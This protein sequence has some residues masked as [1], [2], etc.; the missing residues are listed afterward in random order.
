MGTSDQPASA[1][2]ATRRGYD[3]ALRRSHAEQTRAQ[4][5]DAATRLFSERGWAVGMRE[6]AAEADVSFETVYAKFGSK[7][8]LFLTAFDVA[9]VGDDQPVA[10]ARRPEFA[11]LSAG[12]RHE[13][14]AAAAAL[15]TDIYGRT[16]GLHRA[17]REGASFDP[18]LAS[19][20][21]E[22]RRRQRSDVRAAG[23]AVAGR[24]LDGDEAEGLWSVISTEVYDLLVHDAG[25]THARYREWLADATLRLLGPD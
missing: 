12:D 3:S 5:L 21:V 23:E 6:I 20:L 16:S 4:I 7:T 17:L 9:V 22:A 11:A 24:R 25:W 15:A 8:K 19:R 1:A 18:D 13:R 10:L 14:A 2:T